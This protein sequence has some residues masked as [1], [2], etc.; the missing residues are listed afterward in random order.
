MHNLI[1]SAI[2]L[3][4]G[5]VC[6][7][8]KPWSHVRYD[9]E[10]IRTTRGRNPPTGLNSQTLYVSNFFFSL[11]FFL[12]IFFV[13]TFVLMSCGIGWTVYC[14]LVCFVCFV[15]FLCFLFVFFLCIFLPCLFNPAVKLLYSPWILLPVGFWTHTL[16]YAYHIVGAC[17]KMLHSLGN[18]L[19][20]SRSSNV[21]VY[22]VTIFYWS[23]VREVWY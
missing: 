10:Y 7:P 11:F 14:W 16:K 12:K 8:C 9:Y 3:R 21:W 5:C 18:T 22:W 4:R 2:L 13:V 19:P 20:P 17:V 23:L 6:A 1:F 15:R